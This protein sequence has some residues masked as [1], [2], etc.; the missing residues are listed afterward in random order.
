MS[1]KEFTRRFI[2]M[3]SSSLVV[4]LLTVLLFIH[5]VIQQSSIDIVEFFH[6]VFQLA[7]IYLLIMNIS[8]NWNVLIK[9]INAK[10]EKEDK[11]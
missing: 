2:T 6:N 1:K 8:E 5:T 4:L 3:L 9:E 10:I 7:A 11:V